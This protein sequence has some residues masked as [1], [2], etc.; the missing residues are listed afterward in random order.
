MNNAERNTTYEPEMTLVVTRRKT[1]KERLCGALLIL[2]GVIVSAVE[3][4]ATA[5]V[6]LSVLGIP[7]MI[8]KRSIWQ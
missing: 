4:D 1:R 8:G 6:L 3:K 7:L 2:M 5:L